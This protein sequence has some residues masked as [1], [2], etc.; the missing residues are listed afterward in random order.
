MYKSSPRAVYGA[1]TWRKHA[2][3]LSKYSRSCLNFHFI[4]VASSV[5]FIRDIHHM[6][7]FQ[8]TW[9]SDE[10]SSRNQTSPGALLSILFFRIYNDLDNC[11]R[12]KVLQVSDNN[13]LLLLFFL[14]ALDTCPDQKA[15]LSIKINGLSGTK[16]HSKQF[17][18]EIAQDS[19]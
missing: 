12:L 17:N 19:Q 13:F 3:L 11:I 9:I 1:N 8:S 6:F 14:I 4:Q 16:T 10:T 2:G 15:G 7:L 18:A 5:V